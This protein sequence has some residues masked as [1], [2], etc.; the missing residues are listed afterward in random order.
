MAFF[1]GRDREAR[2]AYGFDE[3]ALVPG[4]TTY[5]PEEVDIASQ[6]GPFAL[7][8]PFIASAMDG[9]TDPRFAVTMGKFGGLAV[10][11]LDGI[12]TRYKQPEK[13]LAEIASADSKAATNLVQDLYREPIQADLIA[14]RIHA[15]KKAKAPCA[16]STIPQNAEKYGAIAQ[17]AGCDVFFIQATLV[18]TRHNSARSKPVDLHQFVKS[19]RIPVVIGNCVTYGGALDLIETGAAG[20]LVGVGPGSACTT[21]GV[22]G[23]GVPQVTAIVD[24]AAARDFHCK[25]TG[26]Y[27]SLVADGGMATGG[28]V[29]KAFACGADAVM[30]GSPFAK[31]SEAPGRGYHWGMATPHQN[32]PRGTRVHVGITG[33]LEE[34]LFGPS[35]TDDGTQN[36]VGALRTC[37]AAVG[38]KNVREMQ[39]AEI[40]IAPSIQSEGKLLQRAQ[41]VG[42]GK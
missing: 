33:T 3:I 39:Q 21:R 38:A 7:R 25:R 41:A 24:C 42:M 32:L 22:L 29:C 6:L 13:V 8:I 5:D 16:V 19:M 30:M 23:L 17:E 14:E 26:R 10:L 15:I 4:D 28:D 1:I 40:V 37:M 34:I 27:V 18:T 31:C 9:V 12:Y 11:N 35:R 2:R 36:L 20:I